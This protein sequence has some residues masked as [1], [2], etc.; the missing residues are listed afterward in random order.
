MI[1]TTNPPDDQPEPEPDPVM[2]PV[3]KPE[4]VHDPIENVRRLDR[5]IDDK[6]LEIFAHEDRDGAFSRI[7]VEGLSRNDNGPAWVPITSWRE[8]WAR[9]KREENQRGGN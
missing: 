5:Y 2:P 6:F 3:L 4:L 1:A 8:W 7:V 9:A